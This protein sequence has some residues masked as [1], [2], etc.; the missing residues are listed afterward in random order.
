V[1]PARLE[2]ARAHDGD[3]CQ[4]MLLFEAGMRDCSRRG[5]HHVSAQMHASTRRS[6]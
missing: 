1:A 2:L 3:R 6:V 4:P 5:L